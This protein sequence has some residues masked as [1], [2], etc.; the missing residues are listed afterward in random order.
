[1]TSIT[2]K[3]LEEGVKQRLRRRAAEHGRSLEEELREILRNA[4][5]EAL[6]PRDLATVLRARVAPLGGIEL[7]LPPREPLREPPFFK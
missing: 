3:N 5:E 7:E 4:A 6:P 2:I 1:M